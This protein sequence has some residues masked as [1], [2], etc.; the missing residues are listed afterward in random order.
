MATFNQENE[1]GSNNSADIQILKHIVTLMEKEIGCLKKD[2][3]EAKKEISSMKENNANRSG[4]D[5]ALGFL[6]GAIFLAVIQSVVPL[7]FSSSR[8]SSPLEVVVSCEK[9]Q[10]GL[11]S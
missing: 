1:G 7:L 4:R 9:N 8:N 3:S 6:V 11:L 10:V 5:S 2:F